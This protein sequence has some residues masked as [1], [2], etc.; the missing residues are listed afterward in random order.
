MRV[1]Q[2]A[3]GAAGM[4][5]GSCLHDNRLAAALRAQGHEVVLQPLYTPLRTDEVD[6]STPRVHLGGLNVYLRHASALFRRTPDFVSRWLDHP[7]LLRFAARWA[8][9]TSPEQL[10]ALTLDVLQGEVGSQ[11]REIDQLASALAPLQ[12]ALVQLPNLLLAG[13]ARRLKAVLGVPIV[14]ELTGED[15][16]I[17]G[18]AQPYRTRVLESLRARV[19]DIDAFMALTQYYARHARDYFDLPPER[20]HTIPLGIHAAALAAHRPNASQT[21]REAHRPFTVGYL[22][23]VC[24]QKGLAELCQAVA[25]LRAAG[26]A[27]R[28]QVAGYLPPS[29]RAFLAQQQAALH[30]AHGSATFEYVGEV[31]RSGKIEFLSTLDAFSVPAT[32]AEAK[33]L[34]VLEA[35]AAGVP[36]VQPDHGAFPELVRGTGGGLLVPRGDADALAAALARLMDNPDLRRQ[37]GAAG[38]KSVQAHHTAERMAAAA[39]Q[40]YERVVRSPAGLPPGLQQETPPS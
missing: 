6:A 22:A 19:T 20:I 5:C 31:T 39:W 35:L 8:G 28:L 40:V 24:P 32:Y 36:V 15:L 37:L 11:R 9:R 23:R 27:C 12:P 3:A 17:D 18:L 1:V 2:L 16:F 30:A 34:Y 21:E 7:A 4:Y 10:G 14:C 13:L 38:Q 29:E 25:R 26:R 33:G